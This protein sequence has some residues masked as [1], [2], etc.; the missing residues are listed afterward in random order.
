MSFSSRFYRDYGM[1]GIIAA[2]D[3]AHITIQAPSIY[4]EETPGYVY[5]NRKGY[6]SL[7]VML[8]VDADMKVIY[9]DA[10][11]PGS[12]HDSAVW[13]VSDLK[14]MVRREIAGNAWILADSGYPIEPWLL[15]PIIDP[16]TP[17]EKNY[18]KK[19]IKARNVIERTIGSIKAKYRCLHRYRTL[20]Y[21]PYRA[22]QIVYA[23]ISIYNLGIMRLEPDNISDDEETDDSD[24]EDDDNDNVVAPPMTIL[25]A[26]RASRDAYI[27]NFI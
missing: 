23:V 7:N 26:G 27:N 8:A 10:K 18:N 15:T 11:F 25:Q 17:R 20:H 22:S 5:R 16:I 13:Q 2:L 1:P 9:M 4:D 24:D 3:G 19:H 14:A 6:H 21:S 12:V